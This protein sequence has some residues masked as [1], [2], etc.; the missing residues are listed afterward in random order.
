MGKKAKYLLS[1]S[2]GTIYVY[3][4]SADANRREAYWNQQFD[5]I[6]ET[7]YNQEFDNAFRRFGNQIPDHLIKKR[8]T[9]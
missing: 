4:N 2:N 1:L 7:K 6:L 8:G 5:T 9:L 3:E